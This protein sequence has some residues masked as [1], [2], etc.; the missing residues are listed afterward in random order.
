MLFFECCHIIVNTKF[1]MSLA[2][3]F[4]FF[5]FFEGWFYNGVVK[6]RKF[7][8]LQISVCFIEENDHQKR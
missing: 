4:L 1:E 3:F 8:L 2:F 7:S 5:F 6:P